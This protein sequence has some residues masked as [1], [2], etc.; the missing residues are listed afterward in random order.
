MRTRD[1]GSLGR[2]LLREDEV[3]GELFFCSVD[4]DDLSPIGLPGDTGCPVKSE[5][6]INSN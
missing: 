2:F 3:P 5:F 1:G 6:Q 4:A